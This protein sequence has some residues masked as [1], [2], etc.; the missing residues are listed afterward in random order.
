MQRPLVLGTR[1][2]ALA[3][4]QSQQTAD[5][6]TAR[7]GVPVELRIIST[8]G[9]RNQVRPLAELGGKGLFTAELEEGLRVGEIDLAVHSLKDLPTDDPAGLALGAIPLRADPRDVLVGPPLAELPHGAVVGTGSLRRRVQLL[10]LRPDL[11]LIDLRGNV[12]TRLRKRDEGVCAAAVLAA[13]G[14]ARLGVSRPDLRP[15]GVHEMVPAVGQGALAVQ[16]RADDAAVLDLLRVLDDEPT[17]RCVRAERAFLATY[18]GGCNV[19]A[20]CHAWP[21]DGGG[22]RAVAVVEAGALRRAEAEGDDP[23]ALGRA[24]A[25][26]LPRA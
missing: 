10:H 12:D 21:L 4:A 15:L 22:L 23:E 19:P 5:L 24:L 1:G 7:T 20:A 8:R 13:A 6:L 11:Q 26:A 3:L 16:C 17:R 2:S 18:G 14:L 9:D 25:Q